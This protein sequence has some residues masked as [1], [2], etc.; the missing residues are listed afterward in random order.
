MDAPIE[1]RS[2]GENYRPQNYGREFYGP[3]TLRLGIEK[4]RNV[5]TV[6]LAKDMG[7]PLIAEYARRFGIYDNMKP[8]ISMSLGAG[9]TTVLRMATAYSV[10]A[11]GG[12]SV[13]P[14]LID[15]IQD[16]YGRTIYKHDQRVCEG[17]E[18]K[19]WLDQK[20]PN[21][22]DE[23]EQVLDPM[24][25]YQITSMMQGV[26]T[27]GTAPIVRKVGKPIAGKTGTTNDY[28]DAWFVGFSPDL[29][30]A[31]FVG[32][33]QPKR[34]GRAATGGKLAAPIFTEFMKAALA[35]QPAKEFQAPRGINLIAIDQRT[36]LRA[37]VETEGPTI[38]EA[39]KPG[40]EPPSS[41]SIIG[42]QDAM[43]RPLTV[44][45]DADRYVG[46]DGT[47]GLY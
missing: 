11:N 15:R 8:V 40:T 1:I 47:G 35:D 20:E 43:G 10:I 26:V 5:M 7:M 16:R 3:S 44:S 28:K 13:T 22:L 24:T 29:V 4:S 41:Y 39:F 19:A 33:D 46:Q 30:V 6:R 27:R 21:L 31:V 36:G 37:S 2:G 42:F 45:P 32:Y 14:T 9:E 18:A 25:A 17:C 23:R 34:M 38:M 12:R